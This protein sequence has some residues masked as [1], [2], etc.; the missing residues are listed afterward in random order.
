MQ[1]KRLNLY[2]S[3]H[4]ANTRFLWYT[5]Q[6]QKVRSNRLSNL[7]KLY[8]L[9]NRNSRNDT[10]TSFKRT[11]QCRELWGTRLR[12]LPIHKHNELLYCK[13]YRCVT[14]IPSRLRPYGSQL[15]K[16]SNI[17]QFRTKQYSR[18]KARKYYIFTKLYV[19]L[20]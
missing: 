8:G 7:L 1:Y 4:R 9:N 12:T 13:P 2:A 10:K 11:N 18:P 5:N 15:F 16:R 6:N 14:T 20:R 17:L 3:S 19:K